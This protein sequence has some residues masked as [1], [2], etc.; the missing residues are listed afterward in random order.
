MSA[1]AL[2]KCLQEIVINHGISTPVPQVHT[3]SYILTGTTLEPLLNLLFLEILLMI[4][5]PTEITAD[6][7]NEAS[8]SRSLLK[9]L[10]LGV[11]GRLW[12]NH[13][14]LSR[15]SLAAADAEVLLHK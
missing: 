15:P 7:L 2:H 10:E 11:T 1:I 4:V 9:R 6:F 5:Y 14:P 8:T 3:D 13:R 12:G